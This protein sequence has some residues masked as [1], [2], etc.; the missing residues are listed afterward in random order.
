MGDRRLVRELA[1]L[2]AL[3]LVVIGLLW[4]GFVRDA[5]VDVT[6]ASTAA[7]MAGGARHDIQGATEYGQ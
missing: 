7:E 2:V 6:P 1:V 3:K 4:W 5:R